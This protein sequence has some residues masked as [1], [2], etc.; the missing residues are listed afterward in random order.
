MIV[1][2]RVNR[3]DQHRPLAEFDVDVAER[4]EGHPPTGVE[5]MDQTFSWRFAQLVLYHPEHVGRDRF[6]LKMC[7][8]AGADFA[9]PPFGSAAA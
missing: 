6:Q 5:A 3:L 9:F 4:A 8:V 7:F 1:R 2:E